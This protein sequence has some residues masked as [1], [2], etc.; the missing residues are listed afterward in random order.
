MVK[1]LSDAPHPISLYRLLG[2]DQRGAR[3][4]NWHRRRLPS[5]VLS[6]LRLKIFTRS[7]LLAPL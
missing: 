4:A 7:W 1:A 5:A 3:A 2:I 6:R